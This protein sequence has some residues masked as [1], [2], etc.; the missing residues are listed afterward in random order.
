MDRK[1]DNFGF[2]A[3]VMKTQYKVLSKVQWPGQ[4][5]LKIEHGLSEINDK[6]DEEERNINKESIE[7]MVV[8][9]IKRQWTVLAVQGWKIVVMKMVMQVVKVWHWP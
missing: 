7:K 6:D 8:D 9:A 5:P 4:V 3:E 1:S 2:I